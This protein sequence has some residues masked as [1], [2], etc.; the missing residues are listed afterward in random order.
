MIEIVKEM[1][2]FCQ[3]NSFKAQDWLGTDEMNDLM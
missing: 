3:H 1:N 2:N